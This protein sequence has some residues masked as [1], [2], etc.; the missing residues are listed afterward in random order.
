M[1]RNIKRKWGAWGIVKD[2][3]DQIRSLGENRILSFRGAGQIN[4]SN[5]FMVGFDIWYENRVMKELVPFL[6]TKLAGMKRK[7]RVSKWLRE[8]QQ[9]KSKYVCT[10]Y[11]ISVHNPDW[12][13]FIGPRYHKLKLLL[14]KSRNNV[15][16]AVYETL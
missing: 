4:G 5:V 16:L 3:E 8:F 14:L 6:R 9:L 2:L 12:K 15:P 1:Q 7:W 10:T 11:P 13:N